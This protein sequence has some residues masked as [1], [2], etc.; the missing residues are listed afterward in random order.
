MGIHDVTYQGKPEPASSDVVNKS[1]RNTVELL[2]NLRLLLRWNADP[3]VFHFNIHRSICQAGPDRNRLVVIAK[4][5]RII[6][7]IQQRLGN[8]LCVGEDGR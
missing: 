7:H 8:G 3:M 2:E 6:H 5:D 4:L 1:A